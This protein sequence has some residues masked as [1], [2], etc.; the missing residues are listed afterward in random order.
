MGRPLF[1]FFKSTFFPKKLVITSKIQLPTL[2]SQKKKRCGFDRTRKNSDT[3]DDEATKQATEELASY[4]VYDARFVRTQ[5]PRKAG[6]M[7]RRRRP[8]S[9]VFRLAWYTRMRRY[10]KKLSFLLPV[11][12]GRARVCAGQFSEGDGGSERGKK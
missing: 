12:T 5:P 2:I 9:F 6:G 10:E 1:H 8:F 4:Y 11:C 3:H 7:P